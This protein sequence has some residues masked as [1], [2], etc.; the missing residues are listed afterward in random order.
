MASP[1]N[2]MPTKIWTGTGS[3]INNIRCELKLWVYSPRTSSPSWR[4]SKHCLLQK[5]VKKEYVYLP[6]LMIKVPNHLYVLGDTYTCH[7]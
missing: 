2:N 1:S 7:T 4:Y 6:S 5:P 3:A